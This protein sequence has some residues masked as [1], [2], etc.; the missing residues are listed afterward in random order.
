M[1]LTAQRERVLRALGRLGHATPEQVIDGL[2][3]DGGPALPPSTV[4]RCLEALQESGLV[5]HTHL[6]HRAPSYQL[7]THD[8]H[9]HLVC[10]A[11]GSVSQ[12]P[13]ALAGPF[14]RSLAEATGFAAD[15]THMAVHGRCASCTP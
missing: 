7:A 14:A 4:Y 5:T 8:D 11:C 10:R 3:A 15:V 9:I 6:D 1:R 13:L 12:V 2:P